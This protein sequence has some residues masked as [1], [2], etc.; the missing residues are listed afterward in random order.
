VAA[1]C[2]LAHAGARSAS[3]QR[4]TQAVGEARTQVP[5]NGKAIADVSVL[6]LPPSYGGVISETPWM[7][8]L[9]T[10]LHMT[11]EPRV[12]ESLVLLKKGEACSALLRLETERLLRGQ[13]YLADASVTAYAVGADSVRVEVVTID[14]PAVL[15]SVGVKSGNPFLRAFQF[16][17]A[18]IRGRGVSALAG[19]RDGGFYRDTWLLRYSNFQLFSAPVQMHLT[20]IRPEHGF[21]VAGQVTYPFFMDIQPRAWRVAGGAS[22][23]RVPFQFSGQ[24]PV[25]LGVRRQFVD[26]G[27]VA[28]LGEPG[29]LAIVGGSMTMER[30][31]P[32]G[33]PVVVTD[34]GLVPDSG[35]VLRDRYQAFRSSRVNLLI[36]YRQVNFLRVSGFDALS[37]TQDMRRGVQAALTIGRGLA[38]AG[39]RRDELFMAGNLYGGVGSAVS[40][41][42]LEVLAEGRRLGGTW[43][44]LLVSG[45]F[46][47]YFRPHPRHTVTGS[48]EYSAGR[49]Q[50]LPFQLALGDSRGGLR[51][52]D[53]AEVGGAA[54]VVGRLEERWRVGNIRGN[55]DLGVALFGE[56]GKMWAGDAPYGRTTNLIPSAGVA[57]L[58][59][60]PPRS[61]RIWRLDVAFPLHNTPGA[62]WGVRLTNE[63]RTR[64]FWNEPNDVRRNRERSGLVTAFVVP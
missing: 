13:P 36:G 61:R 58:A 14:E 28:R 45:R 52:Y 21:D 3:A 62:Q 33:E 64:S 50:W 8:R 19:W 6:S 2:A 46:G 30:G 42:G 57:L 26:A 60:V 51:G 7:N 34:S 63:D 29:K 15:G 41:A 1:L 11:T 44:N 12:V 49:D 48:V 24:M 43:Q 59:A 31:A 9:A 32:S 47:T 4:S 37:G 20:A 17:N 25:S 10:S 27:A 54:R 35:S 16:G 23:I 22:I 38:V 40:F 18:N 56:V 5:C 55:G 39:A 53:D